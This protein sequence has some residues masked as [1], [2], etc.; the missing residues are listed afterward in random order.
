MHDPLAVAAAIEPELLTYRLAQ[1]A[2]E[3]IG[4]QRGRTVASFGE[5]TVSV[6]VKV[7][8]KRALEIVRTLLLCQSNI[9]ACDDQLA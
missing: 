2:V 1:V 4:E 8:I 6:A 7:N 9:R 3:T 5:G